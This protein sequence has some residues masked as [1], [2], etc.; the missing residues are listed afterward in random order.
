[1]VKLCL[2]NIECK[3]DGANPHCI[4]A[5]LKAYTGECWFISMVDKTVQLLVAGYE[6][7][8]VPTDIIG[9]LLG[10]KRITINE[11]VPGQQKTVE[12]S[13]E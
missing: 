1:M 11:F 2:L 3:P 6:V 10:A 9:T 13:N 5:L 4:T 7:D 8:S 12:I